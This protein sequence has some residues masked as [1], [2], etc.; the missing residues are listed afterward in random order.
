MNNLFAKTAQLHQSGKIQEALEGYLQI[1][2]KQPQNTQLLYLLGTAY[3]QTG[4]LEAAIEPLQKSIEINPGNFAAHNNLG[5][6]LKDLNR[7]DEA[8]DNYDKAID[9]KPDFV[10]AH[11]NRGVVLQ[12]LQRTNEALCSFELAT[13]I[14]P[15]L[16]EAYNNLGNVLKDLHRFDD[17]LNS[18]D[19]AIDLKSNFAEAYFNRGLVLKYLNRLDEALNSYDKAI[20]IKP[21]YAE[22]YNSR[23]NVLKELQKLDDALDSYDHAIALVSANAEAYNNRGLVLYEL[24]RLEEAL[25]SYDQAIDLDPSYA[26]AYIN[27]GNTFKDLQRLEDAI[28]NYNQGIALK[29]D[30]AEAYNNR[31]NA[32]QSLHR[33]D[34]ALGNYDQAIALKPDFVDAYWNKSL[35]QIL[36]GNYHEGWEL[37]EWRLLKDDL[38]G[39]FYQYPAPRYSWRG[40][41]DIRNQRILVYSEQGLGDTIQF[42]RYLPQ[43]KALGCDII[44]ETHLPLVSLVST[45]DCEMTVIAK[46]D[47]QPEFDAYCPI[48]SL[49]YAFKTTV[50]TIPANTPYLF[51]DKNK[52]RWWQ[53]KLGPKDRPRVGLVWSGSLTNIRLFNRSIPFEQILPLLDLPVEW[54]SL[55]K[56]YWER[57]KSL[58][59]QCKSI[60]QH[61]E[62]LNDFSDTAALIECMDMVISIDTSVA[63]LAGAMGKALWLLVR[64]E[65]DY[66]W[67]LGREDTPWYP[68]ARLFRQPSLGDWQSVVR[69]VHESLSD[70]NSFR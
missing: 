10:E 30:Y 1:L 59:D 19:R 8:L 25:V 48:M 16:A 18:L 3:L 64:W 29:P 35:L 4:Q 70:I 24:N 42:C 66:R 50:E 61:Q 46:G 27:R 20:D 47:P 33:F 31:G 11:Y 7:L 15:N 49:P 45:L 28:I 17:A 13:N 56:E 68:T 23:G 41:R 39:H 58:F 14:N 21:D 26:G 40:E 12:S 2:P 60:H 22:A 65:S 32:L 55:Q 52:V 62:D 44:L 53:A 36:L 34:E 6:A 5:N 54:H 67:M 69:S 43:V 38:K 63:H 9:I 51:A 37:Y 57:D